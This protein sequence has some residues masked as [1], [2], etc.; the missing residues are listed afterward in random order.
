[1]D[2]LY[3]DLD[4][5]LVAFERSFAEILADAAERADAELTPAE[6]ERY[7]GALGAALESAEDPYATAARTA[8]LAVDPA[9]FSDAMHEAEPAATAATPG[10]FEALDAVAGDHRLGVL[11]NGHGPMQRAK[12]DACGLSEYFEV[13]VASGEVGVGKPDPEIFAAAEERLPAESYTFVADELD[14][15]VRAAVDAGWRGIYL[16]EEESDDVPRIELLSEL[17]DRFEAYSE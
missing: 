7:G 10:A 16:G 2:A 5:T 11:T 3:F 14:R 1:M 13:V 12:L 6:M 15:V 8:E 4:G 9:A 17:P